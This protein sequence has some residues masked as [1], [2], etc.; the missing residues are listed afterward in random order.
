MLPRVTLNG[1]LAAAAV[2]AAAT[3][4]ALV[5][6]GPSGEPD[7]PWTA[8]SVNERFPD[9]D[10]GADPDTYVSS[11]DCIECHEDRA[12][13]LADSVHATL[14]VEKKGQHRGCESCHGP[15]VVHYDAAGE[16]PI[17]HPD[18]A[19]AE[20]VAG[21]CLRCHAEVLTLP[22]E[23]HRE[24]IEVHG[25]DGATQPRSCVVCHTV[26]VDKSLPAFDPAVGP[27]RTVEDAAR[28]A[29]PVTAAA[30]A[31]C[32]DRFHPEMA[33]S[34]HAALLTEDAM[35][36]TCHGNGSL[37]QLSGGDPRK[38]VNPEDQTPQEVN[39]SCNRCHLKGESMQRWTCAEHAR[40]RVSCIVCHDANAPRGK[41]LRAPEYQLCGSC[42]QDVKARLRL[43]NRHRVAEG[44]M[45]CSDC[46]DPH[47]N[48]AR[49]KDRDLRLEVC[50]KCHAEKTQPFLYD[51][52]I[53]RSE[54]C[55]A[56]HDPHG[57]PN[58]RMLTHS[59]TRPLCLQCHPESPHDLRDRK[60]RNCIACHVE[61]HG[62]DVDRIFRR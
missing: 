35:C 59:T 13:S 40:E 26:H 25:K 32:H 31:Q 49:V 36:G 19:P 14:R 24:W 62:S 4:A 47:G 2:A 48:A 15:G 23:E 53:K 39:A 18:K 52:G 30:C 5:V 43:G 22:V 27:F 8:A 12:K 10:A 37:H 42:H 21:V 1:V 44:R 41:T 28:H 17:R 16:A 3:G 29:E 9:P 61:I 57:S 54:G 45:D 11:L 60:Y 7:T 34:G 55:V 38:I 51:H 46:H 50:G 33:R 58:R 20:E 56:C 6:A